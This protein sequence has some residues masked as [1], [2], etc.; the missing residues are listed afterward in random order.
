MQEQE[1][2]LVKQGSHKGEFITN[3]SFRKSDTY[4]FLLHRVFLAEFS[5]YEV[6]I[7]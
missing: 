2:T 5:E 3:T 7:S 1:P 6:N 4:N